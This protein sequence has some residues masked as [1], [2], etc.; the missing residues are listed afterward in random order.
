[1]S[2]GSE[3]RIALLADVDES[4]PALGRAGG[5]AQ[6]DGNHHEPAGAAQRHGMHRGRRPARSD[7]SPRDEKREDQHEAEV[8]ERARSQP[9]GRELLDPAAGP[10]RRHRVHGPGRQ[11]VVET[12]RHESGRRGASVRKTTPITV[13]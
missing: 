9:A 11:P 13:W 12:P 4:A 3:S 1:M 8:R 6:N 10:E 2:P 7:E 5:R